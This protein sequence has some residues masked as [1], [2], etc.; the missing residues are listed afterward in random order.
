[1][2]KESFKIHLT[3]YS[4]GRLF[5]VLRSIPK[6][7]IRIIENGIDSKVLTP[8]TIFCWNEGGVVLYKYKCRNLS[9]SR[10]VIKQIEE[11]FGYGK[12]EGQG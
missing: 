10:E 1:M 12:K 8:V 9:Y 7:V 6:P 4:V 5:E 2:N 3:P 11:E